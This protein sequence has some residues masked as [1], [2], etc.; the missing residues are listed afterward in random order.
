MK[1]HYNTVHLGLKDYQCDSCPK[2]F[3][4]S[5]QLKRHIEEVHRGQR[6]HICDTCGDSFSQAS[7]LRTHVKSKNI[8]IYS[9]EKNIHISKMAGPQI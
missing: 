8:F 9:K 4:Q 6:N 3:G 7:S 1:I 2:K 5:G